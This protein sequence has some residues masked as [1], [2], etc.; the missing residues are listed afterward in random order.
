[1]HQISNFLLAVWW[2]CQALECLIE[3]HMLTC[4]EGKWSIWFFIHCNFY[5]ERFNIYRLFNSKF[6]FTSLLLCPPS[7][8][9]C[10]ISEANL[11][12]SMQFSSEDGWLSSFYSCLIK[13]V[14]PYAIWDLVLFESLE[15]QRI[16]V[17]MITLLPFSKLLFAIYS[18]WPSVMITS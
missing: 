16:L 18:C 11:I 17:G 7:F 4:E 5:L 12:S 13:K 14:M 3:N 10:W 8:S 1:M 15:C 9:L 2:L 6:I